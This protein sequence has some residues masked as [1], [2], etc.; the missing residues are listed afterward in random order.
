MGHIILMSKP[1]VAFAGRI[2]SLKPAAVFSLTIR[3]LKKV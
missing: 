3:Y 1:G 2:V